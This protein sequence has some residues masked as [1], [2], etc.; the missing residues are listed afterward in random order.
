MMKR[1]FFLFLL[2]PFFLY[3]H[4]DDLFSGDEDPALFHH[5]N[6]ISGHLNLLL[7]DGE[8]KGGKSLPIYRTYTS[9]GALERS[10]ENLD[11]I[12]KHMRGGW[13]IQ[14]G[15]NFY[16]HAT[17]LIE[18]AEKTK[19][20]KAYLAEPSGNCIKYSF[21][22]HENKYVIILRPELSLAQRSGYLSWRNHPKNNY[23]K[24]NL[25]VGDAGL[26][27]ADGT[28]R[29]YIG[30]KLLHNRKDTCFYRLVSDKLPE[31]HRIFYHYD[32][33]ERLVRLNLTNPGG[34]KT[35]G[36]ICIDLIHTKDPFHF[37]IR[38]SDEQRFVARAME[39]KSRSYLRDFEGSFRP[40]EE[41]G[42]EE[43]RKGIGARMS[44]FVR[45]G[46]VEF[47]ATYCKPSS[48]HE[49]ERLERH[50]NE[51]RLSIDRVIRLDAPLGP[52]GE[53]VPLGRFRYE[54][55]ETVVTCSDNSSLRYRHSEGRVNSI[56]YFDESGRLHSTLCFLWEG[57]QLRCKAFLDGQG[58][59]L[60]AKRLLYDGA[61]NVVE[62]RL[63]GNLTGKTPGPFSLNGQGVLEGAE[64][65]CKRYAYHGGSH[66]LA[67]E[68]EEGG[69]AC[70]YEYLAGTDL[71]SAKLTSAQGRILKR[72]F[73]FYDT[74]NLL[75][76]ESVDDG[77]GRAPSDL[78]CVTER[79]IKRYTRDPT[80]GLP[81]AV[82]ELYWDRGSQ[83]ERLL[84]RMENRY[85]PQRWLVEELHFDQENRHRFTLCTQYDAKGNITRKTTPDGL[86][87]LYTY[88]GGGRLTSSKEPGKPHKLFTYDGAGRP[89]GCTE[90]FAD[91]KKKSSLS[92]WDEKGRLLS[93]CD[94]REN[95]TSQS[96][97]AFGN[98]ICTQFPDVVDEKG[99]RYTPTLHFSYDTQGN[100]T[101]TATPGKE[102]TKNFYTTLR[103]PWR[104]IQ[105]D[106]T[107]V[108]HAY[109]SNGNLVQTRYS[110]G[111]TVRFTY[112]PFQRMT[113]RR[114]FSAQEELL[115]S[116]SWRYGAFQLLSHTDERGLETLY[117]YDGA[118]RK[119]VETSEGKTIRF[120]YDSLGF[121]ERSSD[122]SRSHVEKHDLAGRVI[123]VWEEEEGGK[124]ENRMCFFYDR[125]GRKTRAL[126]TTSQGEAVDLFSYDGEGRLVLHTDPNGAV[127]EFL[128]TE[129]VNLL[130]QKVLQKTAIDPLG[131]RT[132]E[133]FD[134]QERLVK[135]EKRG[136]SD[137]VLA[138]EELFYDRSGNRAKRVT[139]RC[140][141]TKQ[142]ASHCVVWKHDPCGRITAQI[143]AEEKRTLF[144]YDCRGRLKE[145]RLPGGVSLFYSYDGADRLL[146]LSS[147]D[148]RV[149]DDYSY[150]FGPDPVSIC[151]R[152]H[153]IEILRSYDRFGNPLSETHPAGVELK[154][155][156]DNLGRLIH[157]TLPDQS[158]IAYTYSGSHLYKVERLS[159]SNLPLYEHLYS[160][161]DENG[162]VAKEELIS[163]LGAVETGH[164]LLERP[165]TQESRYHSLFQ[166]YGPSGLVIEK[167]NSLLKEEISYAY[168]PLGQLIRAGDETYHFD[169]LGNPIEAEVNPLNQICAAAGMRLVYD[170]DGNPV[171][172]SEPQGEIDYTY[173]PLGRL[174]SLTTADSRLLFAYDPLSRLFS[175]ESYVLQNGAWRLQKKLFYL[176]DRNS[177]IGTCEENGAIYE[178][179]VLGL[180][181]KG[182]IGAAVAIEAGC[183]LFAPLHDFNGTI[184]SLL[185]ESGGVAE[186][187]SIDPFGKE[188]QPSSI[189]PW[190]FCSK[191][192]EEGLIFFGS[193]FYDPSLG[194]WLT[195]DPA[196]FADGP[197]LYLFVANT[198]LNRLDLFGLFSEP[199]F[200][201]Q[202]RIEVPIANITLPSVTG[203]LNCK[204]FIGEVKLDSI[205]IGLQRYQL[206]FSPEELKAGRVNLLDHFTE[207]VPK[208][209]MVISLV[210]AQ[211]GIRTKIKD[212]SQMS[213]SIMKKIPETPLFIGLHNPTEGLVRDL[214]R[215]SDEQRQ[216]ETRAVATKRQFL[217]ALSE[218]LGK[219]NPQ[220]LWLHI[221]HSEAGALTHRAIEG[222]TEDQK[223]TLQSH[224]FTLAFGPALPISNEF[225]LDAVNIYSKKD[226]ITKRFAAPFITDPLYHIEIVPCVSKWSKRNLF[227][228]DHAFM[229]KTYQKALGKNIKDLRSIYGFFNAA[230]R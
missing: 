165:F 180:G 11:L 41:I 8:V 88:D 183:R 46:R 106:Q 121:P 130:G 87:N 147:S 97:D 154:W 135:R 213:R 197:N 146:R 199:H 101:E 141:D 30:T 38:T 63:F 179:K 192:H 7:Q 209:G 36:W 171:R 35:F 71:L 51:K 110:D 114:V 143:E 203:L 26:I 150:G 222:M 56:A 92:R 210:T 91:G 100:L 22:H 138:K 6:V 221:D 226:H 50:P 82:A 201:Q 37:Q 144:F 167:K 214:G 181:V 23:L 185:S 27:C 172:R 81:V 1:V 217:V 173:D 15:W 208:E 24:I 202:F 229:G 112:D 57:E 5:V 219:V 218:Q 178:L 76:E 230:D 189:N 204:V 108:R 160:R 90:L 67:R 83:S 228:A 109:E 10:S 69:L 19:H 84:R 113:S 127:T 20:F 65:C 119:I 95:L 4:W 126:R 148:G 140:V 3:A 42:Y 48:R 206:H 170:G 186:R 125:E 31:G 40:H 53:M 177:E 17:L 163:S 93:E 220:A 86:E 111:T 32:D 64:S 12:Y 103:K 151:D 34:K 59:A 122:G 2:L 94:C 52:N 131:N 195:P 13:M 55:G 78:S 102:S 107:E 191:R 212:F 200:D 139:T 79:R 134:A 216:I 72:E 85:S 161:F 29:C 89:A 123:E 105:P 74:D 132:V 158:A 142:D 98:C 18:P 227:I 104:I 159:P 99:G 188:A 60:F 145:R 215:V 133:A 169:S 116:E 129:S 124:I 61:G 62:E 164:D 73:F 68:E 33:K 47:Q 80:H 198:P 49:E 168:D 166:R 223:T 25:K 162:H 175:K 182:E 43:G 117:S 21:S 28:V 176:Y 16:P 9:A 136:P 77:S 153:G 58:R 118:G 96:Y 156:Y 196:D 187:Y 66:L 14:G 174:T 152:V 193:R 224:L 54:T 155:R 225:V 184:I 45:D 128:Y 137:A 207:I 115:S 149:C 211:N 205:L 39:F 190:R 70:D 157:F 75:R 44:R 194:R 120:F